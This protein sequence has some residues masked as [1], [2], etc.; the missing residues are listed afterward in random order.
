M[1]IVNIIFRVLLSIAAG[2]LAFFVGLFLPL[3]TTMLIGRDPGDIGGG[4][5]TLGIG[6]PIGLAS[7]AAAGWFS[8]TRTR[9]WNKTPAVKR[10]P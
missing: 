9:T 10:L 3:W 1:R 2:A 5:L 7:A 8:F 6:L 4:F